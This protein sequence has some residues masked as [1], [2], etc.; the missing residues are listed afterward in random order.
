VLAPGATAMAWSTPAGELHLARLH[1]LAPSDPVELAPRPAGHPWPVGFSG[2][3]RWLLVIVERRWVLRIEVASGQI[4]MQFDIGDNGQVIGPFGA[5]SPDGRR[6]LCIGHAGGPVLMDLDLAGGQVIDLQRSPLNTPSRRPGQVAW[7]AAADTWA[8]VLERQLVVWRHGGAQSLV[9]EADA[10]LLCC[11]L[12]PD[13]RHVA[14]G[15]SQGQ[16]HLLAWR[17]ADLACAAPGA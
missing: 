8:R 3:G 5:V 1:D 16:V 4:A 14:A 13:G 7:A 10:P 9:W 2:D 11:A 12:S 17:E 6:A 15:D